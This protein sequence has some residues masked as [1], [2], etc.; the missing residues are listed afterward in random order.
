MSIRPEPI[1]SSPTVL[2]PIPRA[3]PSLAPIRNTFPLTPSSTSQWDYRRRWRSSS[4]T[5]QRPLRLGLYADPL[6][7]G[8]A[9]QYDRQLQGTAVDEVTLLPSDGVMKGQCKVRVAFM[10]TGTSY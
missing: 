5:P 1:R 8:L 9:T 7:N 6:R 3:S 10:A 4:I 2:R